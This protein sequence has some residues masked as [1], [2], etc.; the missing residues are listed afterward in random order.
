MKLSSVKAW[1]TVALAAFVLVLPCRPDFAPPGYSGSIAEHLY[2]SMNEMEY[3][4]HL[5]Q[6]NE[7]ENSFSSLWSNEFPSK[8]ADK[9]TALRVDNIT[10]LKQKLYDMQDYDNFR[11]NM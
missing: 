9:A 1:H 5:V 2:R 4:I 6:E 11:I 10:K 7:I 3:T 8:R